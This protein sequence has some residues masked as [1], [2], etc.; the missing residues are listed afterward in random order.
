MKS[1]TTGL[2]VVTIALAAVAFAAPASRAATNFAGPG[3]LGLGADVV[4]QSAP[5]C[6]RVPP[7]SQC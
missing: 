1:I 5:A 3:I 4:Q 7:P 6:A 2:A